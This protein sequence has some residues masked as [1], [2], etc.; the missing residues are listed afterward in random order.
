M[1]ID[2]IKYYMD[3][4]IFEFWCGVRDVEVVKRAITTLETEINQGLL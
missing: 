3:K 2:K 1:T 4:E